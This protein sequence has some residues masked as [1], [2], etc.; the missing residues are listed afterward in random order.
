MLQEWASQHGET[1]SSAAALLQPMR[2]VRRP[3]YRC[4]SSTSACLKAGAEARDGHQAIREKF[5]MGYRSVRGRPLK[6]HPG[7]PISGGLRRAAGSGQPREKQGMKQYFVRLVYVSNAETEIDSGA[8]RGILAGASENNAKL[9]ITGMLCA[10]R[11]QFLQA[12]EGPERSLLA[13]YARI[14]ADT[15]HRDVSLL[16][17]ELAAERMFPRWSLGHVSG[18]ASVHA[19][20]LDR[21]LL[22]T[23]NDRLNDL[24]RECVG[25]LKGAAL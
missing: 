9:G 4:A 15:R 2:W 16:S 7:Q 6:S 23:S 22:Q 1:A 10:G 21:R 5:V 12:L 17:I 14:A 3:R 11:M 25:E 13:L 24:L 8:L 18:P 19:A 20:L